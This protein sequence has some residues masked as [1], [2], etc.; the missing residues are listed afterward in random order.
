MN[1]G[2]TQN[3]R[4]SQEYRQSLIYQAV[5]GKISCTGGAL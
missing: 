5:T 1:L 3:L 2:Q 4:H